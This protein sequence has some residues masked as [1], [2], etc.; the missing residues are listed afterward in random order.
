MVVTAGSKLKSGL[1]LLLVESEFFYVKESIVVV[2][3]LVD[4]SCFSLVV[5]YRAFLMSSWRTTVFL[6]GG[7]S[8][9]SMDEKVYPKFGLYDFSGTL[10]SVS[11]IKLSVG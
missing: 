5:M 8:C 9:R 3:L 6:V 7:L 11:M 1:N 4:A 10:F 2:S